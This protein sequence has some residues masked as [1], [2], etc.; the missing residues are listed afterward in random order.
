MEHLVMKLIPKPSKGRVTPLLIAIAAMF[1]CAPVAVQA[2]FDG[3]SHTA[4][5]LFYSWISVTILVAA[6]WMVHRRTVSSRSQ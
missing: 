4:H 1:I 6:L 5:W 2:H 3:T